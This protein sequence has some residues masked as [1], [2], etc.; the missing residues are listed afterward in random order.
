MNYCFADHKLQI[1]ILFACITAAGRITLP[2]FSVI[3]WNY[4]ISASCIKK[5]HCITTWRFGSLAKI[6]DKSSDVNLNFSNIHSHCIRS[7][8]LSSVKLFLAPQMPFLAIFAEDQISPRDRKKTW[9]PLNLTIVMNSWIQTFWGWKK[10]TIYIR[11]Y[12]VCIIT[13]WYSYYQ[14]L[15]L[16]GGNSITSVTLI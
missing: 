9:L 1:L 8:T 5:E 4:N 7:L 14:N 15:V 16:V 2:L 10:V 13:F 6:F 11:S 3:K 12:P